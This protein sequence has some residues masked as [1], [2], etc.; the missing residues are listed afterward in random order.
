MTRVL[1]FFAD[2]K[3]SSPESFDGLI[4]KEDVELMPG[5]KTEQ[6]VWVVFNPV[7]SLHQY[8]VESVEVSGDA[9]L[10]DGGF[11]SAKRLVAGERFPVKIEWIAREQTPDELEPLNAQVKVNG[12]LIA[13]GAK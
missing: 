9:H 6:T 4:F 11:E 8:R 3:L 7:K 12:R 10:V 1:K 13:V 5:Q 2:E